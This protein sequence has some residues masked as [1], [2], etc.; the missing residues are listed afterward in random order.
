MDWTPSNTIVALGWLQTSQS[1]VIYQGELFQQ[2]VL[3]SDAAFNDHPLYEGIDQCSN[4]FCVLNESSISDNDRT[5]F[6]SLTE[7]AF[8]FPFDQTSYQLSNQRESGAQNFQFELFDGAAF[9]TIKL[10]QDAFSSETYNLLATAFA[11]AAQQPIRMKR[12]GTA[13]DWIELRLNGP[14]ESVKVVLHDHLG[15]DVSALVQQSKYLQVKRPLAGTGNRGGFES[16]TWACSSFSYNGWTNQQMNGFAANGSTNLQQ[17]MYIGGGPQMVEMVFC[18][19]APV[20]TTDHLITVIDGRGGKT[21]LTLTVEV[22]EEKSNGGSIEWFASNPNDDGSDSDGD[23]VPNNEDAFP[24]DPAASQDNDSDGRPD[25]WNLGRN[26]ADSTSSPKL[27]LDDDDDNDGV[28]DAVDQ[29]PFD[30]S[31]SLDF[32]GDGIG[33]KADNDDDDDGVADADD[34]F[35]YDAYNS[36]DSDGDGVGDN[37]DAYPNDASQQSLSI[38]NALNRV[39]DSALRNCIAK[40]TSGLERADEVREIVCQTKIETLEG[41]EN[42]YRVEKV[43]FW[44]GVGGDS[45]RPV[46]A[47]TQLREFLTSG[48]LPSSDLSPLDHLFKLRTLSIQDI[49]NVDSEDYEAL[50]RLHNLDNFSPTGLSSYSM[51]KYY[52]RLKTVIFP[53][54]RVRD[55]SPIGQLEFLETLYLYDNETPLESTDWL[56]SLTNLT[57]LSIHRMGFSD[58]GVPQFF[59]QS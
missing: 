40:T 34:A 41:I 31:E 57:F 2:P 29:M 58:T 14:N 18:D 1:D 43:W 59:N 32:D 35:P 46:S 54:N 8:S 3:L 45:L 25:R 22:L 49:S 13:G 26:G 28:L 5:Y 7:T 19:A 50:S 4:N 11:N 30:A 55:H 6:Y 10:G 53:R 39:V 47:L 23:G 51:L 20:G 37:W 24:D 9:Q 56:N 44:D 16:D 12:T 21:D 52:P 38:S 36:V 33:D 15:A 17:G 48:D 27:V 42:F